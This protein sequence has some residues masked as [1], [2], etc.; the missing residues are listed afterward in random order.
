MIVL[1]YNLAPGLIQTLLMS[2]SCVFLGYVM[3]NGERVSK[4][5]MR[6][7][8]MQ[9]CGDEQHIFMMRWIKGVIV[10]LTVVLPLY[11]CVW[12]GRNKENLDNKQ[13]IYR[14][15]FIYN[16][17]RYQ[18][19]YWEFIKFFMKI[20]L[21]YLATIINVDAKT[22]GLTIVLLLM[23]YYYAVTRILP[24]A[25][26]SLNELEIKLSQTNII[27]M[28]LGLLI[29]QDKGKKLKI[30]AYVII[31]VFNI[32]FIWG[33]CFVL[34]QEFL[35]PIVSKVKLYLQKGQD[36]VT[37]TIIGEEEGLPSSAPVGDAKEYE[38]KNTEQVKKNSP[39]KKENES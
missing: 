17:Y 22:K 34:Y 15:G 9:D 7:F 36:V 39:S 19:Y 32:D 26:D 16:D 33:I 2:D 14:Y 28:F 3:K 37:D 4:E 18:R 10:L 24:F 21:I 6:T 23:V 8:L 31:A 5:G 11:I 38:R 30:L 29:S 20:A 12:V 35:N 27:T 1:Y 25:Q 13:V